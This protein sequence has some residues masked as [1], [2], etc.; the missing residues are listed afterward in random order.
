ML[1]SR[2]SL[3]IGRSLRNRVRLDDVSRMSREVHVRFW[4]G[5]GVRFPRAT[6]LVKVT[7]PQAGDA[8][9]AYWSVY[10]EDYEPARKGITRGPKF[11]VRTALV[12]VREG[13][14]TA[15]I[16]LTPTPGR[17]PDYYPGQGVFKKVKR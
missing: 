11:E 15:L 1:G 3:L 5:L 13:E 10:R 14:K 4:E 8:E 2:C 9:L 17:L 7:W 6:R 16:R 12:E